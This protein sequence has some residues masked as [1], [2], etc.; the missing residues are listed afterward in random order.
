MTR[1]PPTQRHGERE[2]K[3]ETKRERKNE[4]GKKKRKEHEKEGK[5][6]GRKERKRRSGKKKEKDKIGK[7]TGQG[8]GERKGKRKEKD[9]K[10][11]GKRKR[12][13]ERNGIK[14]RRRETNAAVRPS[15]FSS[16]R[17]CFRMDPAYHPRLPTMEPWP[18]L[19]AFMGPS[20][21]PTTVEQ[22]PSLNRGCPVLL[23]GGRRSSGTDPWGEL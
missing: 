12:K 6:N 22:S 14:F 20:R 10:T 16:S 13:R 23:F 15:G 2:R 19:L 5:G 1:H 8:K 11:N 3:N 9:R 18:W 17:I 4:M 21:F 7:G